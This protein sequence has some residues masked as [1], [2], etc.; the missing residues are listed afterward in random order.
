MRFINFSSK[1][2]ELFILH[3][4]QSDKYDV[5]KCSIT[6]IKKKIKIKITAWGRYI[7]IRTKNY[8]YDIY[9]N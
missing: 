6:N 1:E 2:R 5:K 9:T 4:R 3:K 7:D 8:T